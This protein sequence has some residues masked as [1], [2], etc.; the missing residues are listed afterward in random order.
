MRIFGEDPI[1]Q[2]VGRIEKLKISVFDTKQNT[3]VKS[4]TFKAVLNCSKQCIIASTDCIVRH[5][6]SKLGDKSLLA[7]GSVQNRNDRRLAILDRIAFNCGAFGHNHHAKR[8]R[9]LD[10]GASISPC[11]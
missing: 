6:W 5:T 11:F 8:A 10:G 1:L 2:E 7:I 4:E 9:L 3:M